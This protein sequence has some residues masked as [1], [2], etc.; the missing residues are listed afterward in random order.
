MV[1]QHPQH[2]RRDATEEEI[3]E[4]RHVVDSVSLAVWVALVA[5]A[6]ER[7]TFY[8]VTTPW[9]NY[10]QNPADSVV[11]P[12]ALG[13][14]QATATNITSAF[15]FL[16]F[17]LPTVWAVISDTW[18]GRHR[19][20]CLSYFLNFCGCLIIFV[21][22]LPAFSHSQITKVV[23]LGFAMI[24]LGIGTAGVKATASPFIG[25]QYAETAPQVITTKKGELVIADRALTLQYIYNVSYWLTNIASLSLVASTYLEK[26]V[27]FW[28]AYLLPLCATWTLVPLLL[29][30]HKSLI[31]Q[32]PQ[33]NI[34]PRASR[35][36]VCAG[37]HKFDWEAATP[38]YQSEK[39]GRQVEWDDKFVFEIKR[40]GQMRLGG[41]PN[42]TIQ[43]L[44][45]IACVLLGPIMQRFVYPI[46][47]GRGFAF[48][49]IARITWAFIMM[50]TAM[51]YAAG[52]QKLIYTKGACYDK[53]LQCEKSPND[54]SVW[55]QSPVYFLLG[56]AEILGFT[57]LAEYSYSEAPRNMRSL[58][59]AMAQLSSGAGSALG[60]AFSPLSKDPQI[61]YLYTGL[62]VTMITT[63]PTFWLVFRAYDDRV[64]E[65]AHSSDNG[66]NQAAEPMVSGP[67]NAAE[68]GEKGD[69][70]KAS[71]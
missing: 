29:I 1:T 27:G 58:V 3:K 17:L 71:A 33:A 18:L 60:M 63:A 35:V 47:R 50:S 70:A 4:L 31:K 9:Q 34:L 56:V 64:F 32:K 36:I 19:T 54:V 6:T 7:F 24:V 69:G 57:T 49:P 20:L 68:T 43:A 30:F 22:S 10:I 39:F 25:D 28:A 53:P 62:S 14:G 67:S 38:V 11:V 16:C 44:N 48:G 2:E 40:A 41:I 13:L 8:A 21:T 12:G 45:S 65:E 37:R 61:L 59:Q 55:I 66:S 52:V 46:V 26:L 42:D 23:G 5:N 15:L 51:A